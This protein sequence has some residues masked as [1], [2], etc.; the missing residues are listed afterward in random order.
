MRIFFLARWTYLDVELEDMAFYSLCKTKWNMAP[1]GKTRENGIHFV[2]TKPTPAYVMEKITP[3]LQSLFLRFRGAGF[4]LKTASKPFEGYFENNRLYLAI[5][6]QRHFACHAQSDTVQQKNRQLYLEKIMFPEA[7]VWVMASGKD[8]DGAALAE[9]LERK[10]QIQK[11]T[12]FPTRG[13]YFFLPL[14]NEFS[15]EAAHA[16]VIIVQAMG[17]SNY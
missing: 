7:Y 13:K 3:G 15:G 2:H 1:Y 14:K 16:T 4:D 17:A 11:K 10:K 12:D 9:L 8:A 6:S 5:N